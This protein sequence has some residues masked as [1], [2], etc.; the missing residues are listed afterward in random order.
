M[1]IKSLV[2]KI[3]EEQSLQEIFPALRRYSLPKVASYLIGAFLHKD[4]VIKW[5]AIYAFG[6]VLGAMSEKDVEQA[7]IFIRRLMWML[8]E[9]SASMPWGVGEA[10]G[11]ALYNSPILQ[12]EYKFIYVSYIWEDSGNFLEFQPAQ[13]GIVWGLGRIGEK[14]PAI[15]LETN[16]VNY[17]K[18]LL[19]KSTDEMLTFFILHTFHILKKHN[20]NLPISQNTF[21]LYV[22]NLIQK[23]FSCLLLVEDQIRLKTAQELL[24]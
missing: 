11:E 13:R 9:E 19:K 5:K 15:L 12:K 2:F 6:K 22:K 3:L 1:S 23:N 21:S 7:R 18:N 17:L 20:L 10:F 16:A 14:F 4:E 24:S 8:N